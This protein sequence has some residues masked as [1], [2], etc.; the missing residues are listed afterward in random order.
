MLV[1][2]LL[3]SEAAIDDFLT[4][5][6]LAFTSSVRYLLLGRATL[7]IKGQIRFVYIRPFIMRLSG[8]T[9]RSGGLLPS[10]TQKGFRF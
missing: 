10:L 7:I 4:K 1:K 8:C 9:L 5:W 6:V 3:F 2:I